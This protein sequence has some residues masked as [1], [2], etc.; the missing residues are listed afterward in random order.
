MDIVLNSLTN[1]ILVFYAVN[2]I[3]FHGA[4]IVLYELHPGLNFTFILLLWS[5]QRI[6]NLGFYVHFQRLKNSPHKYV[7][8][9]MYF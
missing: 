8:H 4:N 3:N 7:T 9:L 5:H 1:I 6:E 2:Y